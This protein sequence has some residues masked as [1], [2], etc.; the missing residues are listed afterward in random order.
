MPESPGRGRIGK[1]PRSRYRCVGHVP[2]SEPKLAFRLLKPQIQKIADL[3]GPQPGP[4]RAALSSAF[5]LSRTFL[6]NPRADLADEPAWAE[7]LRVVGI[8]LGL[9][10]G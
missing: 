4:Q 7:I 2:V 10:H 8:E 1:F 6:T 5:G 9:R 3:P